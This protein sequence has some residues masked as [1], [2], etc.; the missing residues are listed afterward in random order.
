M[1]AERAI[2]L[3]SVS[4]PEQAKKISLEQQ[5]KDGIA[6]CDQHGIE[7]VD[8]IRIPGYSRRFYTLREL[9]EAALAKKHE[10]PLRLEQHLIARDFNVL[11]VRSTSRFAREQAINAEIISK[12]VKWC[13]GR[14]IPFW[15]GMAI[16][17]SN[18]RMMIAVTGL[19]DSHEIDELMLRRQVGIV[20]LAKKGIPVSG[21]YPL[22]HY[23]V[24]DKV[25][26]IIRS[27]LVKERLPM[28]D[29]LAKL[30]LAN[31]PYDLL[32]TAMF[33]EG[34]GRDGVQYTPKV[35]HRLLKNPFFWGNNVIRWLNQ[36]EQPKATGLW[37]FDQSIPA[38][39]GYELFYDT[40]NPALSGPIAEAVKEEMRRRTT[41]F[42]G[43]ARHEGVYRF[44][45]LVVCAICRWRLSY[46]QKRETRNGREFI[47][48]S[49]SCQKSYQRHNVQARCTNTQTINEKKIQEW[50]DPYLAQWLAED[51]VAI[52]QE[53]QET[54]RGSDIVKLQDAVAILDRRVSNL[55]R[56][57]SDADDDLR[58]EFRAQ[59]RST[60]DELTRANRQLTELQRQNRERHQAN[61]LQRA[62]LQEL[63][64]LTLDRF[65]QQDG[66]YVNQML[67]R[68]LGTVRL[69]GH[70][71]EIIGFVD[72]SQLGD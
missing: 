11:V 36:L 59:L 19:Q 51:M 32:E 67:N 58:G 46:H 28:W 38:P 57:L 71:R 2:V 26:N 47:Y 22:S 65:W 3:A 60:K 20:Q 63:R 6:Y 41:V 45:G 10:G 1:N 61:E 39:E 49:L 43:Q 23:G 18:Y 4:T 21:K 29:T 52:D 66:L 37:C 54:A 50:L 16:D 40:H 24:R 42:N 25:G 27:E 31:V 72:M 15:D 12:V 5:E 30:I 13:R 55:V 68:L 56:E 35:F 53:Q 17:K 34:Y 7:V 8:I 62:T 69:V 14:V 33:E 64:E 70:H 9:S 44:S 48:T